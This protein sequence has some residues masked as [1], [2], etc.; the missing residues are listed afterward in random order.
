ML[1]GSAGPLALT[2]ASDT[3]GVIVGSPCWRS[4]WDCSS[5]RY[6]D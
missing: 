2:N 5:C 3:P 6:S 1:V 4:G